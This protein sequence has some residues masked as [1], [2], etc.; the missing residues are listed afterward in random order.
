MLKPRT[1]IFAITLAVIDARL[2]IAQVPRYQPVQRLADSLAQPNDAAG[3][4]VAASG[5]VALVSSRGADPGAGNA[6]KVCV[7]QRNSSGW[8]Q[9]ASLI[10]SVPVAN[11]QFGRAIALSS[12]HAVV[13]TF[14]TNASGRAA[15]Y[16]HVG[17]AFG[18]SASL[19]S[20]N[21]SP[22]DRFGEAAAIDGDWIAIGAPGRAGH[23]AIDL[24][25]RI[26]TT[27][28]HHS[29]IEP[30]APSA[31]W[32]YGASISLRGN[33]L[34]VGAPGDAVNGSEAGAVVVY[35]LSGNTWGLSQ[36]L[37][38]PDGAAG[39]LFGTSVALE[40]N[41]MVIGAY[42]DDASTVDSGSAYVF[43]STGTAWNYAQKLFPETSV[44]DADFGFAVAISGPRIAVGAPSA[45]VTGGVRAGVAYVFIDNGSVVT[46]LL[47]SESPSA[48][49]TF[50]GTDVAVSSSDL[51]LGAPLDSLGGA[52]TGCA[53]SVDIVSDCDND[54]QI[55]AVEIS[56]GAADLNR[57]GTPDTCQ[58]P[59]DFNADGVTG[60]QD[61]GILLGFWGSN[62]S[63]LPKVDIDRD[64][65]V[66]GADLGLLL[67]N[68][69][70][71]Q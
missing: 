46:P 67:S 63:T 15:V 41:T 68:W 47:R 56:L 62:A 36:T 35:R 31:G 49:G 4:S 1:Y 45:V 28:S 26:G 42:R 3:Y 34:C 11:A 37:R 60:G 7:F 40:N 65:I 30:L 12:Q 70:P 51:I 43:R 27:W 13:T 48:G 19:T 9:A 69:G 18:A 6:G 25:V 20:P 8:S 17:T 29:S 53:A 2:A 58:C 52:Y 44:Q 50:A 33:T 66:S 61:L 38:A 32:E 10:E 14:T 39:A 57:D 23:G 71:C 54:G 16:T 5:T 22:G 24:F 59:A 64:G 55:D 21:A